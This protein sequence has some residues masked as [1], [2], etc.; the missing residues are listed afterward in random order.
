M[1]NENLI[2]F[3]KYGQT[4]PMFVSRQQHGAKL[5]D[6]NPTYRRRLV[7]E[8]FGPKGKGW[9]VKDERYQFK[10]F[11]DDY[12][13][14][15]L[16][17]TAIFWYKE[18]KEIYEFPIRHSRDVYEWKKTWSKS[19]DPSRQG[20]EEYQWVKKENLYKAVS[21]GALMQAFMELGFNEDSYYD[22]PNN[23]G[24][25]GHARQN[26]GNQP[27]QSNTSQ[28]PWLNKT[29]RQ[30]GH[31]LEEWRKAIIFIQKGGTVDDLKQEWKINSDNYRELMAIQNAVAQ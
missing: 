1:E 26:K 23:N 4:D 13:S 30:S 15:I 16:C 22:A 19:T 21:T 9:G 7:T 14:T 24:S 20:K 3:Q 6:V 11:G 27:Q 18:G 29:D 25:N 28:K 12:F 8:A 2:Y 31:E 5:N 17:Y 10:A